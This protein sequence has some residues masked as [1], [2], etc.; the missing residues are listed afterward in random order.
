VLL[1]S[2]GDRRHS[3]LLPHF[4]TCIR[5]KSDFSRGFRS[6]CP[7]LC[8]PALAFSSRN[9]RPLTEKFTYIVSGADKHR[10]TQTIEHFRSTRVQHGD[11]SAVPRTSYA[12]LVSKGEQRVTKMLCGQDCYVRLPRALQT[13]VS[14]CFSNAQCRELSLTI[15]FLVCTA[16][17][18]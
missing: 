10:G 9:C 4:R 12:V 3:K 14:V 15:E 1:Q 18:E 6:F 5:A 11:L 7:P 13:T 8:C 17:C 16:R 2:K